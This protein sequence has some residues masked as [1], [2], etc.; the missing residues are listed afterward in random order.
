MNQQEAAGRHCIIGQGGI[1][2]GEGC[3]LAMADQRQQQPQ[4]GAEQAADGECR[5]LVA[6]GHGWVRGRWR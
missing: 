4:S 2:A 6:G 3:D 1:E 5:L